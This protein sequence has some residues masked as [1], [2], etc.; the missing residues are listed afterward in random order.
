MRDPS[1]WSGRIAHPNSDFAIL[2]LRSPVPIRCGWG[3]AGGGL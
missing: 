1:D 3:D 2:R